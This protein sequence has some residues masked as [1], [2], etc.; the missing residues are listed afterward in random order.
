MSGDEKAGEPN[1]SLELLDTEEVDA[2][3]P[4]T[5]DNDGTPFVRGPVKEKSPSPPPQPI[6]RQPPKTYH[7][8]AER[9]QTLPAPVHTSIRRAPPPANTDRPPAGETPAFS[10]E[11][12]KRRIN[13]SS[14]PT[15]RLSIH[16]VKDENQPPSPDFAQRLSAPLTASKTPEKSRERLPFG[17]VFP[18]ASEPQEHNP[19]ASALV[20]ATEKPRAPVRPI[21]RPPD[22]REVKL[23]D[24][25]LEQPQAKK[26]RATPKNAEVAILHAQLEGAERGHQQEVQYLKDLHQAELNAKY[27][28][29]YLAGTTATAGEA[30]GPSHYQRPPDTWAD[31]QRAGYAHRRNRDP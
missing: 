5:V 28:E 12:G 31:H 3:D 1:D 29:G 6:E 2:Y 20:L 22:R 23:L 10:S 15:L 24:Q 26:S 30:R 19:F 9:R 7:K 4:D 25:P 21:P 17:A 14:V 13:E 27:L 18:L 11:L 8:T 16:R